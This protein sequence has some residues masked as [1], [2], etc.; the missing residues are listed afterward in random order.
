MFHICSPYD[1]TYDLEHMRQCIPVALDPEVPEH[2]LDLPSRALKQST[3]FDIPQSEPSKPRKVQTGLSKRHPEKTVKRRAFT[4]LSQVTPRRAE[5]QTSRR[6]SG[7]PSIHKVN[8]GDSEPIKQ[9]PL[10]FIPSH[11]PKAAK[12]VKEQKAELAYRCHA[13]NARLAKK[14]RIDMDRTRERTMAMMGRGIDQF[15]F[16]NTEE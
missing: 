16:T 6:S 5:S 10:P 9:K 15:M 13:M 12:S 4:S 2:I 14:R 8:F 1:V 11:P 7:C 3:L